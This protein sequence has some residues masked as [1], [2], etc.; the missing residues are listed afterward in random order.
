MNGKHGAGVEAGAAGRRRH[1]H[2][3]AEREARDEALAHAGALRGGEEAGVAGDLR[4]RAC[5]RRRALVGAV[6]GRGGRGCL[7]LKRGVNG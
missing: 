3:P 1:Q 7:R 4:V 6:D 2:Q 5:G